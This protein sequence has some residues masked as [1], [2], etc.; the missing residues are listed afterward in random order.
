MSQF[1]TSQSSKN[2]GGEKQYS[3]PKVPHGSLL[4]P[5]GERGPRVTRSLLDSRVQDPSTTSLQREQVNRGLRVIDQRQSLQVSSQEYAR[6]VSVPLQNTQVRTITFAGLRAVKV[7]ARGKSVLVIPGKRKDAHKTDHLYFRETAHLPLHLRHGLLMIA[8]LCIFLFCMV[9]LTPIGQSVQGTVLAR[10]VPPQRALDVAA[11]QGDT[12]GATSQTTSGSEAYY[13]ALARTDAT[14]YGISPYYYERQ[15]EQE[16]QFDP[17]AR[18]AAGAIGIA[19]FTLATAHDYGFDP[20]DP[21]ASLDGGARYMSNLN[22]E[23]N[24]DYRKAL[25]AYNA[26]PGAVDVAVASCG[27]AWLSCMD[28]QPQAYVYIIMG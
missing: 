22:N 16:S 12:P 1:H 9:T 5:P 17:N 27:A 26:G 3:V 7:T 11:R 24:R 20:T 15:I 6:S 18:S 21:V 28:A 2:S 25:A 14:K 19:Q 8:M 10:L 4:L 23:F 13:R